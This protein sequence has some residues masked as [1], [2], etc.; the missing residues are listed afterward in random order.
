[1]PARPDAGPLGEGALSATPSPTVAEPPKT[2]AQYG[3]PRAGLFYGLAAYTIW[4]FVPLYFRAVA[5]VSPG[6]I[7]CHRVLWSVVFLVVVVSLRK[8]WRLVW[9]VLRQGRSMLLLGVG[10]VLIAAN[11]LLFIYAVSSHQVL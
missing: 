11:W 1:M 10:A 6:V 2:G 9:P 8:E 3:H 4:G 7:L 5:E